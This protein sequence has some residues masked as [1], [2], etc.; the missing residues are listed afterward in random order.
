MLTRMTCRVDKSDKGQLTQIQNYTHRWR[1]VQ[2]RAMRQETNVSHVRRIMPIVIEHQFF[3]WV[4]REAKNR[5]ESRSEETSR[6][7]GR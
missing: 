5:D 3:L 6:I 1:V 2:S 4:R 7:L